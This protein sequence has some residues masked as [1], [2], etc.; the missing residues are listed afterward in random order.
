MGSFHVQ[1]LLESVSSLSAEFSGETG[2]SSQVAPDT[3]SQ[4]LK[5]GEMHGAPASCY[6]CLFV[7]L[8]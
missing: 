6:C 8:I 7:F 3:A 4:L 1:S 5:E 2:S